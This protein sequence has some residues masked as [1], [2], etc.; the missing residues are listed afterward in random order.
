MSAFAIVCPRCVTGNLSTD[1]YCELCSLPLGSAAADTDPGIAVFEPFEPLD[2]ADHSCKED[3]RDLVRRSGLPASPVGQGWR[4]VVPL[5]EGRKQAVYLALAGGDSEDR[6][7]VALASVAGP[8]NERD[9]RSLLRLN[10]RAI[11]GHFAIRVLRGEEYFLVIHNVAADR[12]PG[13]DA[14]RLVRRVADTADRLEE[15]LSRGR[16][17]Y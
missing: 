16:D 8:A 11:E 1:R 2:P 5:R 14:D 15:R 9:L 4:I 7:M 3:L 12:V 13:L 6:P 10:A 17:V